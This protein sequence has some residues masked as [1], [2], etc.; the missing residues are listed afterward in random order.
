M[1]SIQRSV[2]HI[3]QLLYIE[4]PDQ[5][6]VNILDTIHDNDCCDEEKKKR[7]EKK[8]KKRNGK[9]KLI[10][11]RGETQMKK[12]KTEINFQTSCAGPDSHLFHTLFFILSSLAIN[13]I[14]LMN[15]LSLCI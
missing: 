5:N 13:P 10:E 2:H 8:G 11:L 1:H 6:S 15:W 12:I 9:E 3:D 7:R 4:N 14:V